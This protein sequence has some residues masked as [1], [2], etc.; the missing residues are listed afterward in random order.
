M[1]A[2]LASCRNKEKISYFFAMFLLVNRSY[3]VYIL[4]M[5]RKFSENDAA[6]MAEA[7]LCWFEEN[8][9]PLPWR[10]R[11]LPYEVLISEVMLQQTQ[12]ERVVSYFQRWIRRF[13]DIQAVAHASEE[14]I[15]QHWEGL[16]Y[17][18]RARY[19]HEAAKLIVEK[20]DG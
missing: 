15:L 8:K 7:L 4:P 11:Y 18:R 6:S 12:M 19:L 1:R 9:R 14:E 13:P 17:Y 20:Y 3:D 10:Q 5:Y 16:G 2:A